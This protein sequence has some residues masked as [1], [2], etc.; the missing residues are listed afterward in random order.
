MNSIVGKIYNEVEKNNSPT[1]SEV[2]KTPVNPV[3]SAA[4]KKFDLHDFFYFIRNYFLATQTTVGIDV[5]EGYIKIAQLQKSHHNYLL[6][7]YRVH[8]IPYKIRETPKEKAKFINDFIVEYLSQAKIKSILGR[9][10][11]KGN[12]IFNF[13]FLLPALSDKDLRGSVSMELKKR[14]PFQLDLKN[15]HF[16]YFV[17]ERF[18]EETSQVFITCIAADNAVLD[19]QLNFIKELKL[20]PVVINFG[21]DALGNLVQTLAKNKYTAVL[22]IGFKQSLLNFYKEGLLQFSREIPVGGDH[23]TQG[24]IKAI[25]TLGVTASY[26]D[27]EAFKHQ[28]GIPTQSEGATEFLTDFGALKGERITMAL[29]PIL[30]R[31]VT[32]ISRTITFH[33]RTYKIDSLDV[34][35]ITGGGSRTKNIEKFLIAN[36]GS[37]S[38][39]TIEKL[40][41]LKIIAGW[42]DSGVFKQEL[43]MEDAV[44]HLAVTLGLCIDKGGK[45]NLV[46]PKEKVEQKALYFMALAH[47]VFPIILILAIGFY[48]FSYGRV[49]FYRTM[50]K[51]AKAQKEKM[52]PLMDDI[53]AYNAFKK[54]L[55]EREALLET[56]IGHQPLWWGILREL[57]N[58]TPLEVTL[59][60]LSVGAGKI[61]KKMVLSGEVI[62]EYAN[63]DLAI[64]QY[65]LNLSESPFFANVRLEKSERDIYSSVPKALF[66]IICELKV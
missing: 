34:L 8:A 21:A 51:Q 1:T 9:F 32:E 5:G 45:A 20:R 62:S 16:N 2:S 11:V 3:V 40:N 13:S 36:L 63:L 37:L 6:T 31:L 12:G 19:K 47:L 33:F 59:T 24:V 60:S 53:N 14:L 25:A 46:P 7:D 23:M 58:I 4:H 26:D 42:L 10:S 27:A 65:V 29:R 35:Y 28:C 66:E 61:P 56:A 48:F 17:T 15:I 50:V 43:A 54:N 39:K 18:N 57:S 64:S 30:E 22:D 49:V 55:A 44:P 52:Q 41:P 38:I